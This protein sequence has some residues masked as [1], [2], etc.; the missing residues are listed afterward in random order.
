M[1]GL[2]T[3]TRNSSN[4]ILTC[5]VLF[6]NFGKYMLDGED[7]SEFHKLPRVYGMELS[8]TSETSYVSLMKESPAYSMVIVPDID[9]L[10]SSLL[11]NR[12]E[13]GKKATNPI[14][15]L[16][17]DYKCLVCRSNFRAV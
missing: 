11:M 2:D 6:A 12:L 15:K 14:K 4:K 7:P 9:C 3:L 5:R 13:G 1:F 8:S 16:M 10:R 17:T